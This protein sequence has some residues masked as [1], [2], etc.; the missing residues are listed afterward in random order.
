MPTAITALVPRLRIMAPLVPEPVAVFA[1]REAA[2]DFCRMTKIVTE[3]LPVIST[4][5]G[6]ASYTMSTST[7][8]ETR[9]IEAREVWVGGR[10][11]DPV[12]ASDLADEGD[13]PTKTGSILSYM[14]E[15]EGVIRPYRIPDAVV[16]IT[17]RAAT[18]PTV[19]ATV[20]D[21]ALADR[22]WKAIVAA[23]LA[24]IYAIPD[25]PFTNP[26]YAMVSG[27]AVMQYVDEA[28]LV[29]HKGYTR[30]RSRTK[31]RFF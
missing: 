14:Q 28:K 27:A 21:D 18:A 3:I 6:V 13:W 17:I 10:E 9:T 8:T 30:A 5:I 24:R 26:E 11:I 20:I 1:I 2:I 7:P 25:Q 29:A 19:A 22:W 16:D 31:A 4:S 23:A 12:T 15:T